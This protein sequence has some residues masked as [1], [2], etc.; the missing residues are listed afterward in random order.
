[1]CRDALTEP[2]LGGNLP[3][4]LSHVPDPCRRKARHLPLPAII[5]ALLCGHRGYTSIAEWPHDQPSDNWHRMGFTRR[6]PRMHCF[7]RLLMAL[8]P[9]ALGAALA[10]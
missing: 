7:R 10:A 3:T 1:M 4:H 6:S 8:D 9:A 5:C 2:G